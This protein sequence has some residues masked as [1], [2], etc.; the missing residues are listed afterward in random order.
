M[1]S[2][3]F[4]FGARIISSVGTRAL[5][6]FGGPTSRERPDPYA[7]P[8]DPLKETRREDIVTVYRDLPVVHAWIDWHVDMVRRTLR[9]HVAGQFRLSSTLV[10]DLTGDDRIMSSLRTRGNAVVGLPFDL[11]ASEDVSEQLAEAVAEDAAKARKRALPRDVE[12]E[13]R[14]CALMMGFAIAELIWDTS[15][16]KRW[17]PLVK[18]WDPR[19]CY[20]DITV[21]RYVVQTLDGPVYV[22]PGN[23][24]WF[25][26]TPHGDH[27]GWMFGAVRAL[28]IPWLIRQFAARDWA[29]WSEKY[30]LGVIGAKAP[31]GADD[32]DK[33][34]FFRQIANLGRESTVLL[35]QGINGQNFDLA[36]Y[37][38]QSRGWDG[39]EAL[40]EWANTA[41]T[42][43]IQGQT[44][45]TE[46]KEGS[47]AA[48]RVH[49]DVRQS[50]VAFDGGSFAEDEREQ[51][52]KPYCLFNHGNADA[53]PTPNYDATPAEDKNELAEATSTAAGALSTLASLEV[54]V[55]VVEYCGK[56]GIPL[57]ADAGD[58]ILKPPPAMPSF[59][60]L[61]R[62]RGRRL[63]GVPRRALVEGQ[64]YADA[65]ADQ[66][67]DG[68][69]ELL[70]PMVALAREAIEGAK[71]YD[72]V[73][74]RLLELVGKDDD[75][76]VREWLE[77][78]VML[79]LAAGSVSQIRELDR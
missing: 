78:T 58:V 52:W 55:D 65:L 24:K 59:F 46:V 48:A 8:S 72:D 76:E 66:A 70:E 75:P 6:L 74:R 53:A 40:I 79:S 19:H 29:R 32:K 7:P 54:P 12:S 39:F 50:E 56:V 62:G 69:P 63:R 25:V 68:T 14:R 64:V 61:S 45:T 10:D 16:P 30:G 44:L 37:E 28:A 22:Q 33:E 31:A 67:I 51:L 5:S 57:R 36:V 49:G 60:S 34:R 9:E 47:L 18:V 13:M 2:S 26:Y 35:P 4:K 42:L 41:I 21:R 38:A 27:R 43:T 23:G 73:R 15:N 71:S 20:Y 3:A 11:V 77:R 1:R 17:V